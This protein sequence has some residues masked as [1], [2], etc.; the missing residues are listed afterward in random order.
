V[1]GR[2]PGSF[3]FLRHRL[4]NPSSLPEH[5]H[6]T[7]STSE[8]LSGAAQSHLFDHPQVDVFFARH[9]FLFGRG[10][11]FSIFFFPLR[12]KLLWV[13]V[14]IQHSENF[15]FQMF[16]VEQ[17]PSFFDP[18][19]LP[20]ATWPAPPPLWGSPIDSQVAEK[21]VHPPP[22]FSPFLTL[23]LNPPE[24]RR[25]RTPGSR[26]GS[27]FLYLQYLSPNPL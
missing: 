10:S 6:G 9:T 15:P 12:V 8:V 1:I 19:M 16:C 27:F 20:P 7:G 23:I 26:S 17:R 25:A 13:P 3:F 5:G 22:P 24:L 21:S 18:H 14:P 11:F 4:K 2:G